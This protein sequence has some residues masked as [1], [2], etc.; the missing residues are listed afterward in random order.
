MTSLYIWIQIAYLLL[1]FSE[2]VALTIC[3]DSQMKQ[4]EL[5]SPLHL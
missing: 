5:P 1:C 4:L 3:L 2:K